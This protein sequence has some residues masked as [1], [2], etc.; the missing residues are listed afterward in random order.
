MNYYEDEDKDY[1]DK[2]YEN[3]RESRRRNRKEQ[4]LQKQQ[5]IHSEY[6]NAI[7]PEY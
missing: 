2:E 3:P 1:K 6:L 4:S 7:Q 5:S